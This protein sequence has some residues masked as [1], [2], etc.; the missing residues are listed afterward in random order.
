MN[1]PSEI[2]GFYSS[3]G[4]AIHTVVDMYPSDGYRAWSQQPFTFDFHPDPHESAGRWNC[5]L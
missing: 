3:L 2:H 4:D 5:L 1:T